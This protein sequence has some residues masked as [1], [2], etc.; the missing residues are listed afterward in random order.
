[1][2]AR[3]QAISGI[4]IALALSV[5]VSLCGCASAY[6]RP[7]CVLHTND[8]HGHI[9]PERVRGWEE[10]SGGAAVL[11]G[12][13]R[14]I[15]ER[16]LK[17]GIPTLLLDAGDIFVGTPEG[18]V[19]GGAAV[20]EVMNVT[21]YDAAAVGNHEF[22]HGVPNLERLAASAD[23]PFL[24][25]NALTSP[26]G[27]ELPFARPY[28]IMEC[29]GLIVGI[30]GVITQSTP[31]IVMPGRIEKVTFS[32]PMDAARR[33]AAELIEQG[34]DFII[35][36]SH[37]GLEEDKKLA[38][39]LE[40]VGLIVGGHS[41]ELLK[42]PLM[43]RPT[44]TII[45]Q[46][47]DSGRYLGKLDLLVDPHRRRAIT[48]R[49]EL[50]PLKE[51]ACPPDPSVKA[52]VDE[53]RARAGKEFDEVVG[54]CLTDL[55]ESDTAESQLGDTIADSMRAATGAEI[56]FH[57]SHGIRA[58]LLRGPVTKRDIYTIMP[59]D[60]TLY[61]M[62]LSGAQVRAILEQS[63]SLDNGLLQVSGLTVS[64]DPSAAAGEKVVEAVCGERP[65]EDG[66]DYLVATNSY[67]A[68][69][70]DNYRVFTQGR[71]VC[72]TGIMDRE[73]FGQY[74]RARSPLSADGYRPARLVAR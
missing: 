65:I 45:V 23:F 34:T 8:M 55:V 58:P 19:S 5:L 31:S 44:G 27:E 57:N 38:A 70:G 21:R 35:L 36:I 50:I 25:A 43:A 73:A 74:I 32:D 72:N 30:I 39:G 20:V 56:A 40:D 12:C 66:R 42:K 29:G 71:D 60:N 9:A 54:E 26:G 10:R 1:M 53:C 14:E 28:V 7:L 11:A 6:V 63:L 33:C 17:A 13:V 46:A 64:Y 69:G 51:D 49:Y 15:R 18:A 22:D 16:N 52:I 24:C 3:K 41:H 47:G 67:L 61:T 62:K 2:S 37:C 4:F 59:F 48:R 68:A